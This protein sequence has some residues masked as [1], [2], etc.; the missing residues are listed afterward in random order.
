MLCLYKA[1]M[2]FISS[3]QGGISQKQPPE[4]FCK[5]RV[6]RNFA[7]FTGK[8]MC[9]RLFLINLQASGLQLYQKRDSGKGVFL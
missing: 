8:H 4:M 5:K 2:F 6:L 1:S 9:Q 3:L 7:K